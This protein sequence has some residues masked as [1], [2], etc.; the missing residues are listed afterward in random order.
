M[1]RALRHF[2][3]EFVLSVGGRVFEVFCLADR[4][5][6]RNDARHGPSFCY[7]SALSFCRMCVNHVNVYSMAESVE[8]LGLH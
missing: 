8:L 7:V 1:G 2:S 3:T 4:R 5:Q 6:S